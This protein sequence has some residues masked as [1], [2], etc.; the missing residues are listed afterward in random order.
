MKVD[1]FK[2]FFFV[3]L[4]INISFCEVL[5]FW[6]FGVTNNSKETQNP[7]S[8]KKDANINKDQSNLELNAVISNS[9]VPPRKNIIKATQFKT[10]H[11]LDVSNQMQQIADST[12]LLKITSDVKKYYIKKNYNYIIYLLQKMFASFL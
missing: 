10:K 6:D 3:Y 4:F 7:H 11:D 9:F 8:K 12:N 2:F 1:N 5:T